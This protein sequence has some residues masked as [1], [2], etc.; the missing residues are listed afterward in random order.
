LIEV[1]DDIETGDKE[2]LG[3]IDLSPLRLAAGCAGE[4]VGAEDEVDGMDPTEP[5][6]EQ[7]EPADTGAMLLADAPAKH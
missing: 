1:R 2:D 5:A 4:P 3:T 7:A 6:I